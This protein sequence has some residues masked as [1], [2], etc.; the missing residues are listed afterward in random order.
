MIRKSEYF[1]LTD[2]YLDNELSQSEVRDFEIHLEIDSELA[3]ELAL[4]LDVKQAITENDVISLRENMNK[5]VHNQSQNELAG[6]FNSF[7]FGLSEEF[8]SYKNLGNQPST[9]LKNIAHSFPKIHLYQHQV[10]SKETIHQFYKEQLNSDSLADD[11]S[12]S[13]Y[14]EDL[15]IEVQNALE[16]NDILDLRANLSQI[17][18]GMPAHQ[19]S[20]EEIDS[21]VY[22]Q[23]EADIRTLFENELMTNPAL[24]QDL[25][26]IKDLELACGETDIINLRASLNE[27]QKAEFHSTSRIEEIEGYIYNEL[28]EDEMASFEA[29]LSSNQ[30][31][32]QE[33]E[34]IRNIDLALKE[35]EVMQLRSNLQNIA[36]KITAEKQTEQSFFNR[37]KARKVIV[38]SIAAS[39]I[40]LLGI[41]GLLT[42][43]TSQDKVYQKFYAAYQPSGISRSA[44]LSA[45][46][47]LAAAMQKFEDK[48]YNTAL[49]LLNQVTY[50]N[51]NNTVAHF[52]TGATL[53]ETGRYQDA[54]NEYQ[55]V[56]DDKDN[57]FTEQAQWY[58]GLCYLQ[59][60]EN[61]K[62]FKQ[63]KNIAD[64]QGFYQIKAQ[65]ILHKMKQT[66]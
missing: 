62:A 31:L 28:S 47:T 53:Q 57:L 48:E 13:P 58:I 1:E 59:N 6:I 54:I 21:Y 4:H 11:E 51:Q 7:S 14:E 17:A 5:I 52:Y 43:Q 46:Q 26:L 63:F 10:A 32:S 66:E 20:V 36:A 15:F 29:E 25:Q 38:S 22:N 30:G 55:I 60:N 61:K 16:E 64:N 39:L 45:N 49:D 35:N 42:R 41:T 23:M 34:L 18:Q 56:I 27:I 2:S 12:L 19:Y 37:F 3:D 50:A 44:R 8:S 33:I 40:L 9:D 65:A 24:A